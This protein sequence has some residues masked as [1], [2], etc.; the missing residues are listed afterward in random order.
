M[1]I[2]KEVY[3]W[4]DDQLEATG[5]KVDGMILVNLDEEFAI[6]PSEIH[7]NEFNQTIGEYLGLKEPE[8]LSELNAFNES[9][10]TN[11]LDTVCKFYKEI[12]IVNSTSSS[13]INS[14]LDLVFS[15]NLH[16]HTSGV[17]KPYLLHYAI[18]ILRA[19][20]YKLDN[21]LVNFTLIENPLPNTY[22]ICWIEDIDLNINLNRAYI[23]ISYI[24]KSTEDHR[25][26]EFVKLLTNKKE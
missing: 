17:V 20:C 22:N 11:I 24:G 23:L 10:L 13:L 9:I 12:Y 18:A 6:K 2:N 19:I 26:Y 21:V 7:L 14:I 1:V 16:E 4:V 25:S 3:R 5:I 15:D 8:N